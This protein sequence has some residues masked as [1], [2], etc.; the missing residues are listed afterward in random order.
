MTYYD[1]QGNITSP[2]NDYV[3]AIVG[4]ISGLFIFTVG[5][6]LCVTL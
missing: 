1:E 3:F 2:P 5:M 6:I 4:F